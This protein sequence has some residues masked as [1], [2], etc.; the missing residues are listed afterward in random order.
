MRSGA[1]RRTGAQTGRG[2]IIVVVIVV[3]V[4]GAGAAWWF[5]LRPTPEKAVKQF[6][7]A[8]QD[9]D[10][11]K[12]RS[13]VTQETL[14]AADELQERMVAQFAGMAGEPPEG[15]PGFLSSMAWGMTAGVKGV[16]KAKIEGNT[17]TVPLKRKAAGPRAYAPDVKLIK[18]GGK[19]KVDLTDALEI[20]AKFAEAFGGMFGEMASKLKGVVEGMAEEFGEALDVAPPE[21]DADTL[22]AKGTAA[23][24]A[25]KLN[26]AASMFQK[27]LDQDPTN[28]EAHW[29]LAW[30]LAEEDKNEEAIAHFEQVLDLTDDPEKVWEAQAA[31]ERLK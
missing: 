4:V 11:E 8:A 2:T 12:L 17:A 20:S 14:Q 22:V 6:I 28:V 30:V 1:R 21:A 18:E 24:R 7:A 27:A 19:W 26:E 16:G 15:G 23:K 25:G 3:V 31:I 10:E 5:F 9:M 13:L 29:A